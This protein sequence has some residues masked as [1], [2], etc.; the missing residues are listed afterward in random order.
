MKK[1]IL[2]LLMAGV[3]FSFAACGKE[4]AENDSLGDGN[5]GEVN[6]ELIS[7]NQET[8]FEL[9][10]NLAGAITEMALRYD[11]FDMTAMENENYPEIF[12][13]AYCQNSRFTFDYLADLMEK[14]DGILSK[15]Q[16]EYIQYSLT[17]EQIDFTGY[18]DE[19]GIDIY[20]STSGL[21]LGQIV[22]YE[23]I[24]NEKEVNLVVTFEFRN[25]HDIESERPT[26]VYELTVVL[27]ENEDSCFD[28]YS[29][30][31]MSK[32][33]VTPTQYG[34]TEENIVESIQDEIARV[35]EASRQ[36]CNIDSSNMG[37]QQMNQH[38]AEW[39]QLWDN[40]LNSLWSRL[41][42]ELDAETKA[43]VLEEQRE[44]IK[45]KEGNVK[46]AGIEA[47]FGSLQPL[48]E[49]ETAAEMTRARV[50]VLAGYLAEVRGEDFIISAEIQE[51]IDKAEPNMD[52]V[53][54][55][56]EGKWIFN[57]SRGAGVGVER[58][59][60]CAYAVEGSN[61]TIWVTGG[62]LFSDLDVVGY[63]ERN[64]LFMLSNGTYYELSFGIEG[65][66]ILTYMPALEIAAYES[67]ET[68]I[69]YP[70]SQ[71]EEMDYSGMYTD[72]QGTDSVYSELLLTKKEDGTYDLEM[73]LYRLTTI[74]GTATATFTSS[75]WELIQ[76]GEVFTFPS[77]KREVEYNL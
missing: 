22:S 21:G 7:D 75:A 61:W 8:K 44:W 5:K 20:E 28:G 62:D 58:T 76:S 74:S 77:G 70:F 40:E 10:E 31:S 6:Q 18:V 13:S 73:G 14:G 51:S 15:E 35:E 29:I 47:L 49:S 42:A 72:T 56:F 63:T 24:V 37:Q 39:Y 19:N 17:G 57:E 48:L 66:L 36:H 53:F 33:D 23:N 54:A 69:C 45:R 4:S 64:I 9:G 26:K 60:D 71:M 38:S 12:I 52:D 43:K 59:K 67:F 68:I 32:K 46:A 65:E 55:Q 30:K 27:E 41:S 34:D 50:Y 3:I 16:V 1:I 11:E 2:G 25:I